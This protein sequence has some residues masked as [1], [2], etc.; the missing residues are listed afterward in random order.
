MRGN[1]SISLLHAVQAPGYA[2]VPKNMARMIRL[3]ISESAKKRKTMLVKEQGVLNAGNAG[4]GGR[5]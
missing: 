3:S 2:E 5:V 1:L 4:R